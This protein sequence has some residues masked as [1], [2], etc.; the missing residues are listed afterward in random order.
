V[1]KA[2]ELIKAGSSLDIEVV[3]DPA[4]HGPAGVGAVDRFVY[5]TEPNGGTLE[6][7]IKAVVT[8]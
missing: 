6:L 5:L 1:P 8:P 3:Y 7:E 4:A 2:N